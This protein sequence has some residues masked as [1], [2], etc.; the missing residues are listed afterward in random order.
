[1]GVAAEDV[2]GGLREVEAGGGDQERRR[3][4]AARWPRALAGHLEH[5][6]VGA[7]RLHARRGRSNDGRAV[8]EEVEAGELAAGDAVVKD[9]ILRHVAGDAEERAAA[10]MR[11]SRRLS[12]KSPMVAASRP[13]NASWLFALSEARWAGSSALASVCAW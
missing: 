11:P 4:Q 12:L 9:E 2:R 3:S 6:L 8:G 10:A 13:T 1:V 7:R 5:L